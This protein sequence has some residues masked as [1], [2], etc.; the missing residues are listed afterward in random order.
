VTSR[1]SDGEAAAA[2]TGDSDG[3]VTRDGEPTRLLAE[4]SNDARP[5]TIRPAAWSFAARTLDTIPGG[6]VASA[7]SRLDRAPT[8]RY[9]T[10]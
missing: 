4:A 9:V 7:E 5:L 1:A 3:K 6:D 2:D 8:E 10:E